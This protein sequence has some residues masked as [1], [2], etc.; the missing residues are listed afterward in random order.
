MKEPKLLPIGTRVRTNTELNDDLL[1]GTAHVKNMA[2]RRP[3]KEGVFLWLW[4]G[5][6][7][8]TVQH[9]GEGCS[10]LPAVYHF[11][12]FEVVGDVLTL[13]Y[14]E[15]ERR[16]IEQALQFCPP[17]IVD[18]G[19]TS[20]SGATFN[21]TPTISDA[22]A[23]SDTNFVTTG[24]KSENTIDKKALRQA[25]K[26]FRFTDRLYGYGMPAKQALIRPEIRALA[27]RGNVTL[28]EWKDLRANSYEF[29]LLQPELT[30]E[31]L[32]YAARH[33]IGN[34]GYDR[35]RPWRSYNE[36]V[37][38]FYA[39]ELACRLEWAVSELQRVRGELNVALFALDEDHDDNGFAMQV[40]DIATSIEA[41]EQKWWGVKLPDRPDSKQDLYLLVGGNPYGVEED[42]ATR[43]TYRE[44]WERVQMAGA[45]AGAEVVYLYEA[46]E[47]TET[48]ADGLKLHERERLRQARLEA[49][50]DLAEDPGEEGSSNGSRVTTEDR[51]VLVSNALE[52]LA[53][54]MKP[55]DCTEVAYMRD[56]A[57]LLKELVLGGARSKP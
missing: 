44:A 48:G 31:A 33:A 41:R 30:D 24:S 45:L 2:A 56:A 25:A 47:T 42:K 51:A 14:A 40:G 27:E 37:M 10:D 11:S 6:D 43:F 1:R 18:S 53:N 29:E 15:L 8:F 4:G 35:G 34:C 52:S 22:G 36:A 28:E 3:G 50:A 13:D 17:G 19:R 55:Q 12:E 5:N 26:V 39:P 38:G 54:G 16:Y 9:E 7:I 21:S 49:F 20:Y 23:T 46:P 57:K 32:L